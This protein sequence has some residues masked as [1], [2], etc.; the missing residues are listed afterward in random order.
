MLEGHLASHP[1]AP[2][3]GFQ[4]TY[5]YAIFGSLIAGAFG[6]ILMAV[7]LRHPSD[8]VR[9]LLLTLLGGV[10]GWVLEKGRISRRATG[11]C[12]FSPADCLVACGAGLLAGLVFLGGLR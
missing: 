2:E 12:Q 10:I 4:I 6:M 9:P 1:D 8:L 11:S 7:E 3:T 5:D